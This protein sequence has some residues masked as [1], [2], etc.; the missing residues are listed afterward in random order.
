MKSKSDF[1]KNIAQWLLY[2]S[3]LLALGSLI[4][5]FPRLISAQGQASFY[6]AAYPAP[7]TL[8]RA[9]VAALDQ[10][11]YPGPDSSDG[12][13]NL[14]PEPVLTLTEK[15]MPVPSEVP[16]EIPSPIP[17]ST[18]IP[19][20]WPVSKEPLPLGPKLLYQ[21]YY[22]EKITLW[23]VS[24]QDPSLRK[25]LGSID[26]PAVFGVHASVSHKGIRVAY[27]IL[28]DPSASNRFIAD[29]MVFD[30]ITQTRR[31]LASRV[32]IGR[33]KHYPLWSPDDRYLAFERQ[34]SK[35]APYT[36]SIAIVNVDSGEEKTL[37]GIDSP[38]GLSMVD[39]SPDGRYLYF[40]LAKDTSELWRL[41]ISQPEKP[42]L[43]S[44]INSNGSPD[45][46]FVSPDGGKI[47]CTVW[48]KSSFEVVWI[49]TEPGSKE[50]DQPVIASGDQ[51]GYYFPIW[52][53]SNNVVTM[54]IPVDDSAERM[55]QNIS[56]ATKESI[57]QQYS[58]GVPLAP[59]GWSSDSRW[60][61]ALPIVEMNTNIY[62]LDYQTGDVARIEGAGGFDFIGW[63]NE[64]IP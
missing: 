22:F 26:D 2:G 20:V 42:L 32:D 35:E 12:F 28:P 51:D 21:E 10:K 37:Y 54:S 59:Y 57:D 18:P 5:A 7:P 45:C 3:L 6:N 34:S 31:K 47:L 53:P 56:V 14:T 1:I 41:D 17:T 33:Y 19:T 29:L 40:I 64:D 16:S 30:P 43:I 11:G 15:R 60:L 25:I 13:M 9:R 44:Q 63:T 4:A 48:G 61:A 23:A 58:K 27:T 8:T 50:M 24:A 36:T 39:W 38:A 55:L 52:Y 49:S 62:I 46:A